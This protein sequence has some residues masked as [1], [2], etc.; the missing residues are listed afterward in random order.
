MDRKELIGSLVDLALTGQY[1][2]ANVVF[3]NLMSQSA[4]DAVQDVT[5]EVAAQ[6]F[7]TE[8]EDPCWSGYQKKGLKKKGKKMVP[9]CVPE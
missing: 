3:D 8:G 5:P 1:S 9:N 6:Y 7:A 4:L 2:D